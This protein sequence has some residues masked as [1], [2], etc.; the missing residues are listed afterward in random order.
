MTIKIYPDEGMDLIFNMKKPGEPKQVI[1][2]EMAFCQSCLIDY[3]APEAYET[4]IKE[5]V[6][7]NHELFTHWEEVW[8]EWAFAEKILTQCND[9][10]KHLVFYEPGTCGPK[11]GD[12]LIERD[13]RKCLS[14]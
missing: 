4:L 8:H 3:T 5:V 14:L 1:T 12:A 2:R 11:A 7:G 6:N 10:Q 13:G 9:L